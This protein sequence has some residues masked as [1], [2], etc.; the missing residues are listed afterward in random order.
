[1]KIL[2][3]PFLVFPSNEFEANKTLFVGKE[4]FGWHSFDQFTHLDLT[5][6]HFLSMV[7]P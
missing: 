2:S 5:T 1:V 7:S 3:C 6:G 4:S